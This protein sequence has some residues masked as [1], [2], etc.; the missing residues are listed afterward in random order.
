LAEGLI[1]VALWVDVV[2]VEEQVPSVRRRANTYRPEVAV[3][4]LVRRRA[5]RLIDVPSIRKREWELFV[6]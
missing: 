4:A 2:T 6:I 1:V 3:R 5:R